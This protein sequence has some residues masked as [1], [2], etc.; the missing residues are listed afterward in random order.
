MSKAPSAAL[1]G[2]KALQTKLAGSTDLN[3]IAELISTAKKLHGDGN[4]SEPKAIHLATRVV[5][6]SFA[7]LCEQGRID[8]TRADD[9]GVLIAKEQSDPASI[10]AAWLAAQW[11]SF[12]AFLHDSLLFSEAPTLR[13]AAVEMSMSLQ[14][15]ASESMAGGGASRWSPTPFRQLV[16]ALFHND[17]Y[18]DVVDKFAED[19]L[20]VYDDVRYMFCKAASSALKNA[21]EKETRLRSRVLQLLVRI[22]AIPTKD[23]HLNNYLVPHLAETSRKSEPEAQD[24]PMFS[25]S[26]EDESPLEKAT[27]AAARAASGKKRS[28]SGTLRDSLH[29]LGAQRQAFATAWLALLLPKRIKS[30]PA[31][32]PLS[33]GETHGILVRLHAQILPH[34]PL[35]NM[36]HDFLV[37]CLDS[38]GTTALLALN[39]LY[40]LIVSHNLDYPAFYTRLYA[41]LDAN[42][43]HTKYR[44]RFMRMLN[45]FLSSTHLSAALV[46]S[47]LKRLSRLALRASPAAIVEVVP[48]VWNLLRRHPNCMPMIHREWDGDHLALGPAGIEDGFDPLEPNPSKTGALESSLWEI[49]AF[50]AHAYALQNQGRSVS[51]IG[52]DA[53]YLASV[54]TFA[55]ILADPFTKQRYE[56]E[57]FLDTTYAT[58]FETEA[59]KTLRRRKRED[60][61]PP[62]PAIR[63]IEADL[64]VP[65][66]VATVSNNVDVAIR[67]EERKRL[68]V[69]AYPA[70]GDVAENVP[71]DECAR[72]WD[73]A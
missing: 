36:L 54:N 5:T 60:K 33:P 26:D 70:P 19:Y 23:E 69:C 62:S 48:F 64:A 45:T 13:L 4:P 47:F 2:V 35:P 6:R 58:L 20:E 37:D 41:L 59:N 72:L 56:L 21:S 68:R 14:T 67:R 55:R 18:D 30:Q 17:V 52:G 24:A 27:A 49:S 8:F 61:E 40:T 1:A 34:L 25:D 15:A 10:V 63:D 57:E 16:H 3:P 38:K 11:N 53:H 44:S 7:A 73:M 42:V 66:L 29:S 28:R 31:G 9:K 71:I 39:G 50:G 65:A 32:G 12:V 51:G 46:A 43:L 22:T